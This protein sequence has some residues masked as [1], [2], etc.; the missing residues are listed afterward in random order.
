MAIAD[1]LSLRSVFH[2]RRWLVIFVTT[3]A[4]AMRLGFIVPSPAL[5]GLLSFLSAAL[6]TATVKWVWLGALQIGTHDI[7]FDGMQNEIVW[8][9]F[10]EQITRSMPSRRSTYRARVALDWWPSHREAVNENPSR[11]FI[12]RKVVSFRDVGCNC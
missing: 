7:V 2:T 9:K 4:R 3:I 6:S 5:G 12:V 8:D 11:V 1:K 10:S